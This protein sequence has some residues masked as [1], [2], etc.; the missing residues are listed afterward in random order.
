MAS[1]LHEP[2]LV[3]DIANDSRWQ[4]PWRDWALSNDLQSCRSQPIFSS[5]GEVL[6]TFAM[7]HKK[8][9]DPTQA[10][11]YQIEV[12]S[13][14]AGIAIERKILEQTEQQ[15]IEAQ[16]R[17]NA[18][19]T[20]ALRQRDEFLS[21][22]SH[23]LSSPLS[24]LRMQTELHKEMLEEGELTQADM[25]QLLGKH[26]ARLDKLI[27]AVRT[28][29]D[30]SVAD[31]GRL[32]LN[33]HTF[34]LSELLS[35]VMQRLKPMF[36]QAKIEWQLNL[37]DA[38]VGSW[39]QF[40]IEQVL[41]NLITNSLKYG[42]TEPI[43]ISLSADN[44]CATFTITDHGIGIAPEDHDKIFQRFER[45]VPKDST[46]AGVGLGLHIVKEIVLA[47]QGHIHVDSSLGT[48]SRF[49]VQLPLHTKPAAAS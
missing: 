33:V 19:L 22:A 27:A 30:V 5:T 7:Y 15:K 42:G 39:D 40:K 34:D 21:I 31:E 6:G 29:L 28:M 24:L 23:E 32:Q 35:D 43:H 11:L 25:V 38:V 20:H 26:T 2:V 41:T 36:Q 45:A 4:A 17:L 3:R 47:H 12:T 37:Q 8:H 9:A 48:G 14:I 46:T 18:E 1:H 13:H 49:T 16:Q 44:G 10:N